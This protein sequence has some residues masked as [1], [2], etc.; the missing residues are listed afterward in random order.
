MSKVR[1]IPIIESWVKIQINYGSAVSNG[2][3]NHN[4][5]V[6]GQFG[7]TVYFTRLHQFS[8]HLEQC[9]LATNSGICVRL[10]L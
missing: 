5:Y 3:R 1:K 10:K 7:C 2:Y 6:F 4:K 8:R 9:Q